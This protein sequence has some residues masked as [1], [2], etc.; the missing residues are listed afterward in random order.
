MAFAVSLVFVHLR[1]FELLKIIDI[2]EQ[3]AAIK[4]WFLLDRS[5]TDLVHMLSTTYKKHALKRTQVFQ[6]YS[7]FKGIV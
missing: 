7:C 2:C 5:A 4:N 3:R 6:W 1:F